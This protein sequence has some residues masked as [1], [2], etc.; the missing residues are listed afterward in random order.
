[1]KILLATGGTGGHI[2]PALQT[3]L[4]L[5]KRGHEVCFA[6]VLG[7]GRAKIEEAGFA[8]ENISAQGFNNRSV[9][10]MICF[11]A[12]MAGACAH[13][14]KIV[15]R[16]APQRIMGFGGYGSFPVVLAGWIL[17]YPV[18]V[19]EQNVV[20]GKANRVLGALA[21][22]VAVS[23]KQSIRYFGAG[24][25]V[26]TGCPCHDQAPARSREEI[27]RSFG[28][29]AGKPVIA[30]LGGSQGSQRLNEIFS[31]AMARTGAQAIHMT[32]KKEYEAYRGKYQQAKLPVAA[33]AFISPV[34]ELYAVAD[35]MVSRCG[36][37]TVSELGA[38]AV[39]AVLVPYPLAD[40][41]QKYNGQVLSDAGAAVLI[42]QKD[43]NVD[44]L[45]AAVDRCR[46]GDFARERIREKTKGLFI[47]EAASKLAD[48]VEGT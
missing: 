24:K 43:L 37:A 38:F 36:A 39:P 41:H 27:C 21:Q 26:W 12:R 11:A 5:R 3:A 48:A 6:G 29:D 44:A 46:T 23:F 28:L 45:V 8:C 22:K 25:A 16:S 47:K 13:S 19:H 2:F 7:M 1:M 34:E 9:W 4:E 40:G 31:Q 17:R 15:R 14:L 10:G 35:V 30:L 18:M 20:P 42:E 32:G 33:A